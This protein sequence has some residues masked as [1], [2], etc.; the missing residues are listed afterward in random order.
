MPAT[1]AGR[2][3]IDTFGIGEDTGAPVSNTYKPPFAFTGKI[4]KVQF[5]LGPNTVGAEDQKKLD[6]HERRFATATE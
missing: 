3:G 1:V 5:H 2:F 4:D 6:E